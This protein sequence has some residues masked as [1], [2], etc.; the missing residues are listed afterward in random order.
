MCDGTP[1]Y[2]FKEIED[3]GK[4]YGMTK[5]K[6]ELNATTTN[7]VG[8]YE[9]CVDVKIQAIPGFVVWEGKDRR[10]RF[11]VEVRSIAKYIM[12]LPDNRPPFFSDEKFSMLTGKVTYNEGEMI[13]LSFVGDDADDDDKP[14]VRSYVA[15][16][17]NMKLINYLIT[18]GYIN[19]QEHTLKMKVDFTRDPILRNKTMPIK[20]EV[21]DGVATLP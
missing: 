2:L 18:E 11:Q 5:R 3:G 6:F 15:R 4:K 16:E 20:F 14:N 8:Y 10:H 12:K 13:D 17:G 9:Y 21:T 19:P 7:R 1:D